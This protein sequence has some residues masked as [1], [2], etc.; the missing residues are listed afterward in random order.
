M[1]EPPRTPAAAPAPVTPDTAAGPA[2]PAGP[3]VLRLPAEGPVVRDA[4]AGAD[5]L[6]EAF[7]AAAEWL[8]VPAARFGEEFFT[9]STRIAGEITQKF[10]QYR[11]GLAVVG[12]ISRH[13]GASGA[14]RDFVRE[15]NR[16]RQLWFLADEAGF[17]AR[18]G[19]SR[20]ARGGAA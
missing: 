5:L 18:L 20:A 8:V 17:D 9:L 19:A 3:V 12:D 11:V 10:A 7:G 1:T 6:G 13:T 14:L 2:D 4:G 16:G 15:S